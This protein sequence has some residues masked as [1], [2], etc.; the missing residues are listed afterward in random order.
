MKRLTLGLFSIGLLCASAYAVDDQNTQ[1]SSESVKPMQLAETSHKAE[2]EAFLAANKVKPGVVTTASGLQYKVITEGTGPQPTVTDRVTVNYAGSLMNGKE[3]DSSY[4]RDQPAVFPVNAV[5][6]GW[7]E[8]LQ[9]M[10]VGSTWE[11][12]IPSNLAYA[13]RGA[14]PMIGPDEVLIFKVELLGVNQ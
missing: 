12:Y 3:F 11:I 9:L 5:I 13:E 1:V 7:T 4:K 8:A 10:K 2:G 6:P 14:P